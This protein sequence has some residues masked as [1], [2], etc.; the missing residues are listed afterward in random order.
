MK[1]TLAAPRSDSSDFDTVLELVMKSGRT[2]TEAL[3]LLV[4][5]V[6][7]KQSDAAEY[8]SLISEAWDGPAGFVVTD[9]SIVCA[10]LTVMVFV[11]F[12][13]KS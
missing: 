4:F 13:T 2:I 9:G 6:F 5:A 3:A 1:P 11:H 12:I 8:N 10:R 7:H